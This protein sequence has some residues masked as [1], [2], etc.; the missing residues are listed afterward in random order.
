MTK[1]F[2]SLVQFSE[3]SLTLP[4]L[5]PQTFAKLKDIIFRTADETK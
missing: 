5:Q 1:D 4:K 2:Y 3:L